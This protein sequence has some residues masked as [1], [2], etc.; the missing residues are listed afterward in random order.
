MTRYYLSY[1]MVATNA[2]LL[3]GS[4]SFKHLLDFGG[5]FRG[6]PEQL[7]TDPTGSGGQ[8]KAEKWRTKCLLSEVPVDFFVF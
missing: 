7:Q 2:T 6:D 3:L 4:F 1:I 8:N 5:S